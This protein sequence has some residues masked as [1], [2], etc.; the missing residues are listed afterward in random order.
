LNLPTI[1]NRDRDRQQQ[2]MNAALEL[3]A[4]KGYHNAKVSDV[5]K[6]SGVSQGTFYW[7]FESKEQLAVQLIEEGKQN[8]IKVIEQGYRKDAGSVN[9]MLESTTRLLTDLFEFAN[10]NRYLMAF[11]LI[12]GQGA[13]PSV[14]EAVSQTWIAFEE[15]FNKNVKRALELGMLPDTVDWPLRVNILVALITGVLAK[16]LFGPMHDVDFKSV[17]TPLEM[18]VETAR[19]EFGGLLG[20][21]KD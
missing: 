15:A 6:I 16:W 1:T 7:Y 18:A 12:K 8:L 21:F 4:R 13:D 5:V 11:L 19:F 14:R 17:Y 20:S 9:D 10:Q 2:L 3:F